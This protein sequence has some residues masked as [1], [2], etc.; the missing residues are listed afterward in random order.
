LELLLKYKFNLD[1]QN[2]DLYSV[3]SLASYLNQKEM[4]ELL[5]EK[6]ASV[7][8][9]ED[10][11]KRP[12]TIAENKK[13]KEIVNLLKE[14]GAK[15]NRKPIYNIVNLGIYNQLNHTTYNTVLSFGL[16]EMKYNTY[17]ALQFKIRPFKNRIV[18]ET[19]NDMY[20][21]YWERRYFL[22]WQMGKDFIIN[23]ENHTE[24]GIYTDLLVSYSFGNFVGT[25]QKP[26]QILLFSPSIGFVYNNDWLKVKLGY[27]YENLNT[28]NLSSHYLNAGLIFN[29][30]NKRYQEQIDY[31]YE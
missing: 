5:L 19:E 24:K 20:Y 3:L 8:Y 21:Q 31:L 1:Y 9:P 30:S 16:A 22:G 26:E 17:F 7:N 27:L 18:T 11:S 13:H 23:T 2:K 15:I 6:G 12:V 10:L 14:N 28:Y 4:V 29:I 25:E